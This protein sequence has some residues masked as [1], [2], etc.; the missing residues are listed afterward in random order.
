MPS[1]GALFLSC[2]LGPNKPASFSAYMA[3]L[4]T[5]LHEPPATARGET[6]AV[7]RAAPSE[8]DKL[9]GYPLP[10]AAEHALSA[11]HANATLL[12]KA[13]RDAAIELEW[14]YE[15]N[16]NGQ[17]AFTEAIELTDTALV[18]LEIDGACELTLSWEH[19]STTWIFRDSET[20]L[21]WSA[22]LLRLVPDMGAELGAGGT[23][24]APSATTSSSSSS[25]SSFSPPP[26][27]LP[28]PASPTTLS[29]QPPLPPQLATGTTGVTRPHWSPHRS[30]PLARPAQYDAPD[31]A[32]VLASSPS[33]STPPA[34]PA[35]AQ[36]D[37][38]DQAPTPPSA[39]SPPPPPPTT[40][41]AQYDA[42]MQKAMDEALAKALAGATLTKPAFVNVAPV[43]AEAPASA[44]ASAAPHGA[45]API[46]PP[47]TPPTTPSRA[48]PAPDTAPSPGTVTSVERTTGAVAG[49][50]VEDRGAS[51][52]A[53][54]R[55]DAESAVADDGEGE[56]PRTGFRTRMP[57]PSPSPSNE[58]VRDMPSSLRL[59]MA[60]EDEEDEDDE[61]EDVEEDEED[62]D[63][64]QITRHPSLGADGGD[65]SLR[66]STSAEWALIEQGKLNG[67]PATTLDAREWALIE[68]TEAP[69]T[70]RSL[71]GAAPPPDPEEEASEAEA[72]AQRAQAWASMGVP[73]IFDCASARLGTCSSAV[74]AVTASAALA[75][76]GVAGGGAHDGAPEY[77]GEGPLPTSALKLLD[78][79]NLA[80]YKKKFRHEDLTEVSMFLAML[81]VGA[82]GAADLRAILREVGMSLGHREKVLLALTTRPA[83]TTVL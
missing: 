64:S 40:A 18:R 44:P 69:N 30:S 33:A 3:P 32:P 75:A 21:A 81:E 83:P 72:E 61:D 49:A 13:A 58:N 39:S 68:P 6:Y 54:L 79:L 59:P 67:V 63:L 24:T 25:S 4:T 70:T 51:L 9:I 34:N 1:G 80:K 10:A 12:G 2:T 60:Q 35:P 31:T 73:V 55:V 22:T 36:H 27:P 23:P 50:S 82:H 26:P 45:T 48:A 5:A 56:A 37:A 76:T 17:R 8:I 43:L 66:Y 28:Q 14:A 57:P 11:R 19:I 42:L 78:E 38:L 62:E 65:G 16:T 46:T 41:G 47:I 71:P 52:V 29:P 15:V 20:P 77:V 53:S 7:V 74:T